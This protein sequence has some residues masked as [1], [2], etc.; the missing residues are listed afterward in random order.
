MLY[1]IAQF[2]PIFILFLLV[3]Y[4]KEIA[5]FSNTVLGKLLAICV[6]V[7]YTFLDKLLGAVVCL[8]V[9]FYY[10]SDVVETMLNMDN[11]LNDFNEINDVNDVNDFNNDSGNLDIEQ[12]MVED[13]LGLVDDYIYIDK[14]KDK[15]ERMV[16][17][18]DLYGKNSDKHIIMNNEKE[19]QEFKKKN[20]I[21]G[22]LM[23]KDLPVN[24]EMAEH[25]F[26]EL[27]FRRGFCNP[28]LKDCEFS[29]IDQKLAL[30]DKLR[31]P[32]QKK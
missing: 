8:I 24:Y 13:H 9:I 30:E 17:Y 11:E 3:T 14:E 22:E 26:P 20:C 21:K 25:V 10:Q 29:I 31:I 16:N 6:I 27:K 19:Q 15:K 18:T 12:H 1:T 5:K 28:C 2:I 7:F 32:L 4:F 23:N